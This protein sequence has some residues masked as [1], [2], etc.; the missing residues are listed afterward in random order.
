VTA[1]PEK[2]CRFAEPKVLGRVTNELALVVTVTCDCD[3]YS[4]TQSKAPTA[5][6]VAQ[7]LSVYW[8]LATVTLKQHGASK[9]SHL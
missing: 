4:V 2:F 9:E 3:C 1:A 8:L 5:T 6:A 7:S